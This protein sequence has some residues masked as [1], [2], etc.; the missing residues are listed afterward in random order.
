VIK[1][2]DLPSKQIEFGK[3]VGSVIYG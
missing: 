2:S 3:L 1:V